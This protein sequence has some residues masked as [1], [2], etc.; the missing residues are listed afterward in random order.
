[1]IRNTIARFSVSSLAALALIACENADAPVAP[2]ARVQ[3]PNL[4]VYPTQQ[5]DQQN[6]VANPEFF[7]DPG[8]ALGQSFTAGMS[9]KLTQISVHVQ[10]TISVPNG[11]LEVY[12]GS[13]SVR[14]SDNVG[15]RPTAIAS[16]PVAATAWPYCQP[17]SGARFVDV[18]FDTP[19]TV[20]AGQ[21][22]TFRFRTGPNTVF[23]NASASNMNP[24]AGG[25]E[26]TNPFTYDLVFKTYV[27]PPDVTPPV[28][29]PTV[30]GL[31]SNGWY[32]N[33]VNV[34]WSVTDAESAITQSSGCGPVLLSDES[35]GTTLTCRATSEGGSAE[36]SVTIRIDRSGPSLN[37]TISPNPVTL[38]GTATVSPNLTIEGAGLASPVACGDVNTS[39]VG[40]FIVTC[41]ASDLL[42]RT[43]VVN[44]PY[45]VVYAFTGFF[46][47]VDAAP[48]QNGAK[49]GSAI[50]VKFSLAGNRGLAIMAADSP[51]SQPMSCSTSAPTADLAE[52]VSAGNSSLTYDASSARY[53]YVWK[54]E[55]SWAGTCR[56][57]T[58]KLID[59][60]EHSAF[61][62]F[63]K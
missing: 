38:G 36:Q 44:K 31:L 34:S 2:T 37:P 41:T 43:V 10:C 62:K 32:V 14:N 54:T 39:A 33:D 35:D 40:E 51:A 46:A 8:G 49:A 56:K 20:T 7:I 25:A 50:P 61:F 6:L 30:S 29:T 23:I 3:A 12:A 59:G 18:T 16:Q 11:T 22:Y 5:L 27:V 19:A 60:T 26:Y 47:P 21:Q 1:M 63:A 15:F 48:V 24:Y 52:T 55:K 4:A 53:T 42:G 45:S 13:Y 28:I 57:L 58:V 9:G 17:W